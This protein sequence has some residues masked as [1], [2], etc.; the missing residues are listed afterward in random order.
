MLT[1]Q[2]NHF[3][4]RASRNTMLLGLIAT[5]LS[6]TGSAYSQCG[7]TEMALAREAYDIG[8]F[9]EAIKTLKPCLKNGGFSNSERVMA[10]RIITI[11]Y[12]ELDSIQLALNYANELITVDP[13]F[14]L[15]PEDPLK[16]QQL[17]GD[18]REGILREL[19]SSVSKSNESLEKA[20]ATVIVVGEEDIVNRGYQDIVELLADLPGINM[21]LGFGPAYANIYQRGY[22]SLSTDRTLFLVDGVEENDLSASTAYISRQIPMSNI[23]RVEVIYGPASTMYGPNACVGVI[24][25]VTKT[26]KDIIR[27]GNNWGA[28]GNVSYGTYNT[29]NVDVTVAG[30]YKNMMVT[31]TG[32][33]FR[34]DERNLSEF[35]NWSYS[36][37]SDEEYRSNLGISGQENVA[38]FITNYATDSGQYYT[39]NNGVLLPT[40]E[41]IEWARASDQ[42]ALD[43]M[44]NGNPIQFSNLT[45]SWGFNGKM[46][47]ADLTLG[48]QTWMRSEGNIGWYNNRHAG[49]DNGDS[50]VIRNSFLYLKYQKRLTDKLGITIFTRYKA[51]ELDDRTQFILLNSYDNGRLDLGDLLQGT[52]AQWNN[53]YYYRI[54]KQL[55]NEIRGV[56]NYNRARIVFGVEVRNSFVQGNYITSSEFPASSTGFPDTTNAGNYFNQRDIGLYAQGTFRAHEKLNIVLGGRVDQGKVRN[57]NQKMVFNPRAVLVYSP[58][59]LVFKAM[60]SRAF[61]EASN[62]A[63]YATTPSRALNNPEISPEIVNNFEIT[64][65]WQSPENRFFADIAA[66]YANYTGIIGLRTVPY[67]GGATEQFANIGESNIGGVQAN[68]KYN[69]GAWKAYMNYSYTN[70]ILT[71]DEEGD[72]NQ[73]IQDIAAH[74]INMGGSY[75]LKGFVAYA[76]LNYMGKRET[77]RSIK[78]NAAPIPSYTILNASVTY[79][80]QFISGLQLQLKINNLLDLEYAH[81]GIRNADGSNY[82]TEIPQYR[83]RITLGMR[84]QF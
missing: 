77:E 41:A 11:S 21:T 69:H 51:H 64:A 62:L 56:Y 3:Y 43:T 66:Y 60:Y 58:R 74:Q 34:S 6:L 1:M 46:Q 14:D 12:I 82:A 49:S 55:R 73:R 50:W 36:L 83:R 31:L 63:K 78:D 7:R 67:Q 68:V 22:R 32:R 72:K 8:R 39:V 57:D 13:T 42:A 59:K 37:G 23:K 9:E 54:S 10:Y 16:F 47:I 53:T 40:Q 18:L 2:L 26:G 44:I 28:N 38:S 5:L 4:H 25:V 75:N 15:R 80:S 30:R 24:N 84:Y 79:G 48:Y 29:Q 35:D 71:K 27:A 65:S 76:G 81:P 19:I 45:D 33:K 17:I 61:R 20:P 52:N 70:P